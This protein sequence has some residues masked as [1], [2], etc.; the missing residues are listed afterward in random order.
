MYWKMKERLGKSGQVYSLHFASEGIPE[1]EEK[2][3]KSV[4]H[5]STSNEL[6]PRGQS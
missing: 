6:T 1:D 4:Q 5:A 2:I 3:R